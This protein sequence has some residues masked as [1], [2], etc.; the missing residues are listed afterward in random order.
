METD[1]DII[2]SVQNKINRP[3]NVNHNNYNY[4]ITILYV[5]NFILFP[6]FFFTSNT[7]IV[8]DNFVVYNKIGTCLCVQNKRIHLLISKTNDKKKK[9]IVR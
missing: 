9:K 2:V 3:I 5:F 4:V 6:F 7:C 8:I 1:I